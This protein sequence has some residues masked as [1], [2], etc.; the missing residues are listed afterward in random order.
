M[1]VQAAAIRRGIAWETAGVL[2]MVGEGAIAVGAGIAAHSLAL[3]AFGADSIIEL[4]TGAVVLRRLILEARGGS[5]ERVLR[6]EK[7]A[8]WVVGAAL[9]ALAVY[10]LAMAGWDVLHHTGSNPS[11][12]GLGVA[13]ASGLFM[14]VLARAKQHIGNAVKSP[15]LTED[16]MCNWVCGYMAWTLIAALI[17][18][19]L[20]GW[21]WIDP[22]AGLALVY[23]VVKE[24]FEAIAEARESVS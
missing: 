16:G 14:P 11:R 1:A 10:I 7:R 23:F 20:W 2:W 21:W 22:A 9:L 13:V 4:V 5:L 24:G 15:A 17:S 19:A 8:S 18:N 6:S 3:T 12:W